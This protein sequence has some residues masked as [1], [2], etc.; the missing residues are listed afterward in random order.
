MSKTVLAYASLFYVE[1]GG[2]FDLIVAKDAAT[3]K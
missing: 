3:S 2:A 1:S